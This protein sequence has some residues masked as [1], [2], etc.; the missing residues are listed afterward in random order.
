MVYPQ[1]IS[2][3]RTKLRESGIVF[4]VD[5][6]GLPL[7]CQSAQ[8]AQQRQSALPEEVVEATF[9]DDTA[10]I[11]WPPVQRLLTKKFRFSCRHSLVNFISY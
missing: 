11:V 10:L 4:I 1:A 6:E 3:V 8:A 5:Y 9:V 2:R 7:W